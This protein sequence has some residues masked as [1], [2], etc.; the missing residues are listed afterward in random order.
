MVF[1]GEGVRHEKTSLTW[2]THQ[3][4]QHDKVEKQT[5]KGIRHNSKGELNIGDLF[6]YT[7]IIQAFHGQNSRRNTPRSV[8]KTSSKNWSLIESSFIRA[9]VEV[10]LEPV[11][12]TVLEAIRTTT[13]TNTVNPGS[14]L[15]NTITETLEFPLDLAA[16]LLVQRGATKRWFCHR[17]TINYAK[18]YLSGWGKQN[19][20]KLSNN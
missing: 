20:P 11:L 15:T 12:G 1:Q 16:E 5:L 10:V 6:T 19:Y 17:W 3:W 9:A 7:F 14:Y 8:K 18:L 4:R 2:S 13:I